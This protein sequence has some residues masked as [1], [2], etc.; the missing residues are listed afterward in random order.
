MVCGVFTLQNQQHQSSKTD[1][2]SVPALVRKIKSKPM[3]ER[4]C[5]GI[6]VDKISKHTYII[7]GLIINRIWDFVDNIIL[8]ISKNKSVQGAILLKILTLIN[9]YITTYC[10]V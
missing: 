1:L 4:H 6:L 3:S 7:I 2:C 9:F 5:F 10:H 8:I